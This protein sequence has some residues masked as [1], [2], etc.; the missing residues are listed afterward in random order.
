MSLWSTIMCPR[1]VRLA[2]NPPCNVLRS[3][4]FCSAS[5]RYRLVFFVWIGLV[6][7]DTNRRTRKQLFLMCV[8]SFSTTFWFFLFFLTWIAIG[9][10]A[11]TSFKTRKHSRISFNFFWKPS[12]NHVETT[13]I[14]LYRSLSWNEFLHVLQNQRL[15]FR[16]AHQKLQCHQ[17]IPTGN[18]HR[19]FLDLFFKKR[20]WADGES[21][22]SCFAHLDV[23]CPE[24]SLFFVENDVW[25]E[26]ATSIIVV[27]FGRWWHGWRR[28]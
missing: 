8:C 11:T 12:K 16:S 10:V 21:F 24:H 28:A 4:F 15:G 13:K 17:R 6:R 3:F 23:Q 22:F 5:N 7:G 2:T 26:K 1:F 9:S 25:H 27:Q 18:C 19:D 20:Y 14:F